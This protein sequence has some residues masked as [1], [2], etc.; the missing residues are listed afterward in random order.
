MRLIL[1]HAL[2]VLLLLLLL[3]D[4]SQLLVDLLLLLHDY[5]LHEVLH[6]V[7]A[8]LSAASFA[9]AAHAAAALAA[10]AAAAAAAVA[11][12]W[13]YPSSAQFFRALQ[14]RGKEAEKESMSAV[15]YVHNFVNEETWGKIKNL[16]NKHK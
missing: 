14:R 4:K 10:T 15:V 6:D 3:H 2:E 9:A 13:V 12:A 8:T 7:A 1:L 5:L 11:A 16:E